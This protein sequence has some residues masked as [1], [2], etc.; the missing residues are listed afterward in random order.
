MQCSIYKEWHRVGRAD[1]VTAQAAEIDVT[2]VIQVEVIP[3]KPFGDK[4]QEQANKR[5]IP[6]APALSPRYPEIGSR[7]G[8]SFLLQHLQGCKAPIKIHEPTIESRWQL[9]RRVQ[10]G[11]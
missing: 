9:F 8:V 10:Y 5:A 2:K 1:S 7:M 6:G 11:R 4:S 3:L